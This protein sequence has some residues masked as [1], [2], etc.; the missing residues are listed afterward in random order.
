[1]KKM[2]VPAIKA[3]KAQNQGVQAADLSCVG[4]GRGYG[5]SAGGISHAIANVA[6]GCTCTCSGT[7]RPTGTWRL[8]GGGRCGRSCSGGGTEG[9]KEN[10][11]SITGREEAMWLS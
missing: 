6:S 8:G 7:H 9:R 4:A 1:M 3:K 2:T 11:H 10:Q 5:G